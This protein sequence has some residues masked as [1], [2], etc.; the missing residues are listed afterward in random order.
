MLMDGADAPFVVHLLGFRG[1]VAPRYS[2]ME[3]DWR[4]HTVF[5]NNLADIQQV[6]ME[7][8]AEP[9][10][11][12]KVVKANRELQ[13]VNLN[14]NE[15]IPQ[16]DTLRLLNF[17]T[18]FTD[19]R[20]EALLNDMAPAR[21]DSIINTTPKNILTVVDTRGD[22]TTIITY[23]KPNDNKAI[24]MEGNLYVHDLDRLYALIND[25]RDFV[26]IQYYVFD[27]VLRPLSYFKLENSN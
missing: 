20:Y 18:A 1:Y 22:S 2:T 4:D 14:T 8:P 12:Y 9:E 16:Y 7:M 6:I 15:V 24:D 11:S 27:K 25:K 17:L 3:K 13:L 21:K 26:L 23:F 10:N 19:I 5:K